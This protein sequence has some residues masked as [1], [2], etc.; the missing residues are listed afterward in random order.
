MKRF[1]LMAAAAAL[2][3]AACTG[4][5]DETGTTTTETSEA[6]ATET[7]AVE[8]NETTTTTGSETTEGSLG[9][10]AATVDGAVISVA[11]VEGLAYDPEADLSPV[12]FAQYLG[13]AVQ[14]QVIEHAAQN[15][16]S[17]TPTPEEIDEGVAR[18]VEDFA[19]G[20]TTAEFL[21]AQNI[22][23]EV[24]RESA[25][26]QLIQD[27]VREA[28]STTVDQP[29]E[30]EAQQQIDS[31]PLQ[32]TTVCV[33]HILVA[34]EDEADAIIARVEGGDEFGVV[35]GEASTDTGSGSDEGNLGC[36]TPTDFVPEFAD[37]TM[38]AEIGELAGP[39]ETEFGFH[40]ILVESREEPTVDGV[41]ESLLEARVDSAVSDWYLDKLGAANVNVVGEYGTWVVQP[42][43]HVEPPG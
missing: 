10:I 8:S 29:T 32:W 34:T 12:D 15:E 28:L 17:I 7:T 18:L 9:A 31:A 6:V 38:S 14:W 36:T 5:G 30:D 42:I 22:S 43:P 40:V 3:L 4:S 13:A 2:V 35:A 16:Y 37:A 21:E 23:E 1:V 20:A 39:V 41:M 27:T 26:Q 33:A 24:L 19:D 11:R 25:V